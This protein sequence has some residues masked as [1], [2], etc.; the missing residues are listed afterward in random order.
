MVYSSQLLD[1]PDE[2]EDT[3]MVAIF[4]IARKPAGRDY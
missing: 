2:A 4:R 1:Y 3:G